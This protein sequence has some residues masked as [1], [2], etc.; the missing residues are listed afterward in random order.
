LLENLI[1]SFNEL[2][3]GILYVI[4]SLKN[5]LFY[6]LFVSVALK[7]LGSFYNCLINNLYKK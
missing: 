4:D 3:F 5:V 6:L 2:Q 7:I 1:F